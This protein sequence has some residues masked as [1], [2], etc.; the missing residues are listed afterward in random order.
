[1]TYLADHSIML[2]PNARR[3]PRPRTLLRPRRAPRCRD[4]RWAALAAA[5]TALRNANR[6]SVRIVDADCGTGTLLLCAVRHART[7]GFSAI[8]AR[9]I[10]ATPQCIGRARSAASDVRDPAI[11]IAFETGDIVAALGSECDLPADI[12]L[13]HGDARHAAQHQARARAIAG[14]GRTVI[15]DPVP[16]ETPVRGEAA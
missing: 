5:L 14:A 9:G 15:A 4:P 7:L 10:G 3:S 16:T 1:M 11:G 8:E 12:V 6:H 13:W 2:S